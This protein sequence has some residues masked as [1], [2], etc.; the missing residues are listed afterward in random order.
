MAEGI[1][2]GG[3][4][5]V[6]GQLLALPASAALCTPSAGAAGLADQADQADSPGQRGTLR[7]ALEGTYPPFNFKDPA[8]GQLTGH[9]IDVAHAVATRIGLE[10]QFVLT[11]WSAILP[12]VRAGRVDVAISQVIITPQRTKTF[13]FSAPYCYSQSQLIVRKNERATYRTL[14][15]LKGRTLGVRQN[16]VFEQQARAV[17]GIN[18]KRCPAAPENLQDLAF[19][20]IDA[21][22]DDSLLVHYLIRKTQL[23]LKAGARIG[24]PEPVGIALRK[25]RPAFKL[26]ID[27]ALREARSDGTLRAL[28][29]KWFGHDASSMPPS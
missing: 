27:K 23:P 12:A 1:A 6:L 19:G 4:R 3:R 21:L 10:P 16:S 5:R 15:D 17:Q 7:I 25:S 29:L 13:D 11:E 9:D 22:L 20:R 18:I 28:S 14:A 8:S 2:N 24:T 26:A